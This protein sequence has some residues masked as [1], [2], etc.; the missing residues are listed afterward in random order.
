[1]NQYFKLLKK[2]SLEEKYYKIVLKHGLAV[3]G[4]SIEIIN[5]KELYDKIDFD[6]IISG[7]LLHDIGSFGFMKNFNN[8]QVDYLKHGIIGGKILRSEGLEKESLI[9]E[10]HIGAGLSKKYI[11]ENNLPLPQKNFL[12]I[13][14]EEKIICYADKFHSKSGKKIDNLKSIK[15]EMKE[16]GAEPLKRF[17]ELEKMFGY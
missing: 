15:K 17:L 9:A 1:M 16:F 8:K 11:I 6:L 7:A 12:P 13:S 4:K 5:K 14:L 3:L 2:Y 10:R